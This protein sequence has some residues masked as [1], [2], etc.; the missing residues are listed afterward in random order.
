MTQVSQIL[1]KAEAAPDEQRGR[2]LSDA[3]KRAGRSW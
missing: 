2:A 1:A 3:G